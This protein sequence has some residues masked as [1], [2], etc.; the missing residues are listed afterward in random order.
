MFF[1]GM[2]GEIRGTGFDLGK[3]PRGWV[4]KFSLGMVGLILGRGVKILGRGVKILGWGVVGV[5]MLG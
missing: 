1:G 2:A 5:K 4:G 3:S